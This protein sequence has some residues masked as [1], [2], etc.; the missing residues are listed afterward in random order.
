MD[1]SNNIF[2]ILIGSIVIISI[3]YGLI[4]NKKAIIKRKLRKTGGKRI[5]EFQSGDVAKAIGSVKYAGNTLIA[6]LSG[7]KCSYY[8]VLVEEKRSSG[9]SSHWVTIVEEERSGD[10]VIKE[11]REYAFI[12]IGMVKNY[13]V[14]DKQ[15]R[16][17][18]L[19]DAEH[20]LEKYLETHGIESTGFFGMNKTI[21]Y[22]EG[23]LEEGELVAVAGKGTW[24]RTSELKIE[25]P[26]ERILV[27]GPDDQVPVYF[28][29]DP[30]V[31]VE[32]DPLL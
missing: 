24:K 2:F 1:H 14:D 3:I 21:S 10:V 30:D 11:G 18:F 15:Y 25:L 9:K 22:K 13:L 23:I 17:G 6:P 7:R 16:S 19:N 31:A 28:S 27:I 4:F 8:H 20:V 5:S 12:E 29:D 26:V 32:S